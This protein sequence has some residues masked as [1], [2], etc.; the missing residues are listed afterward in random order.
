[1]K[2][3]APMTRSRFMLSPEAEGIFFLRWPAAK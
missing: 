2:E 1:L 3:T